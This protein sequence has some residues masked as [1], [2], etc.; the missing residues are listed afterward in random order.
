[1]YVKGGSASFK[2]RMAESKINITNIISMLCSLAYTSV[3]VMPRRWKEEKVIRGR[4]AL[5]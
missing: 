1:M 5:F 2:V 4:L 3:N